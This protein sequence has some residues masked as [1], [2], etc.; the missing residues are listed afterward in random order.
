MEI[1]WRSYRQKRYAETVG[2][3]ERAAFDFPRSDYRPSWLYWAARAHEQ[4]KDGAATERYNLVVADY[5][6]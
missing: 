6:N 2:Y 3:F 4:L 1:G 5:L